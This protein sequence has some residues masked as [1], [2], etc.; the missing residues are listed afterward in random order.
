MILI[1]ICIVL[2]V[3]IIYSITNKP[4]DF[5]HN[6]KIKNIVF[7]HICSLRNWKEIFLEQIDLMKES[8]LYDDIESI[9]IGFLGDKKDIIPFLNDKIKLVYHS[10]NLN[11][12]ENLL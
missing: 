12:Y 6:N 11:E 2:I 10:T 9:N 5:F 7:F 3:L 4:T 8:G 1:F